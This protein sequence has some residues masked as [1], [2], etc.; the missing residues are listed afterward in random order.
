M[1]GM[2]LRHRSTP[3]LR[4]AYQEI[5]ASGGR[6]LGHIFVIYIFQMACF[7]LL[8]CSNERHSNPLHS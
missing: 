5:V 8:W 6:L 4:Q 3:V 7:W 2:Q 1:A